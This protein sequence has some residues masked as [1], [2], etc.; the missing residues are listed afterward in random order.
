MYN[1][2]ATRRFIAK[3]GLEETLRLFA[4]ESFPEKIKEELAKDYLFVGGFPNVQLITSLA[5]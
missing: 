5:V 1:L 2:E 3:H 4:S